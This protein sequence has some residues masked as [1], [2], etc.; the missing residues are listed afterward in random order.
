MSY[1]IKLF[2]QL[3]DIKNLRHAGLYLDKEILKKT[4]DSEIYDWI[5][6]IDL[7]T[8]VGY[9]DCRSRTKAGTSGSRRT[10]SRTARSKTS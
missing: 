5:V 8:N 7:I 1:E 4:D 6:D 3:G 2:K 9:A 10:S